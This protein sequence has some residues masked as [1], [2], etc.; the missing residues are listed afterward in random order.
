MINKIIDFCVKHRLFVF[1]ATVV[2]IAVAIVIIANTPVDALPDLSDTQVIVYAKWDRPPQI[3]EDQVTYPIVTALLGAPGVKDI[4]AFS[5]YGYS[6]V[7]AI[8]DDGTDVYWARSRVLEYLSKVNSQL[9]EGVKVELGP[10]ASGVGWIYEYA[11]EDKSGKNSL[12][13]L[14][15]FQDW[16]LKYALQSVK[17]VS[18]VASIGGFVKQY[19]IVVNPDLL[20]YYNVTLSEVIAKVK[21]A[22]QE[23]GARLLDLAGKEYMVTVRGYFKTKEDIEAIVI[24]QE[25]GA[26]LLLRSLARVEIGPEIR[27]GIAEKDGRGGMVGGIVIMRYKENAL[28]VIERVKAKLAEIQMPEGVSVVP[29]YDRSELILRSIETLRKSLI[30]EMIVVA[31]IIIIFLLHLSSSAVPIIT[32]P[33]ATALAFIPMYFL[34]LSSNIMSLGGIAIA[35]GAMVDA[36]IVSVENTHTKLSGWIKAGRVGDYRVTVVDSLKEVGRSAFYSL[37][38]IAVSFIPI[39]T[40]EGI[41]GRLFRPLALTKNLAMFFGALLAITL[42]PALIMTLIRAKRIPI[43]N[44]VL[45][46][47][48]NKVLVGEIHEEEKHPVSRFLFKI[49]NPVI[50]AVLKKPL[51]VIGIAGALFLASMPVF[52]SLG[53]E[54]MPPLNEGSILYMPSTLP[55]ISVTEAQSLLQLQDKILKSFPEVQT[56]F[57]KAGRAETATD[58]APF[59]MMETTIVLKPQS[60]WRKKPQWYSNIL[61]EF[62]KGPLRVFWPDTISYEELIAEMDARLKL[63]GQTNS[64]TLP[65]KGRIDMLTTGVRTPVGIKIYGDDLAQI[66]NLGKEMEKTLMGVKGTRSVFAERTQGGF[67]VD[68][69]LRREALARYGL[70]IAEVQEVLSY[71]V[72]GENITQTFE[73][74]ERFPVNIRYP[75]EFRDDVEKLR[76]LPVP[77]SMS[78]AAGGASTAGGG[79]SMGGTMPAPA[80]G[81]GCW[82]DPGRKRPPVRLCVHRCGGPRY[83]QLCGRSQTRHQG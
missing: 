73:G 60:E 53:R 15:T 9:P 30:E 70:S 3:I 51:L 35:V 26:P 65:V 36:S 13:D 67:F 1:S 74:R 28:A 79:S 10:D 33:I 2:L 49:Y 81:S 75:R 12:A 14:R 47:V 56:V 7:Y 31:V 29:V 43:K 8:F 52:L 76:H 45:D 68:I 58:P 55:G 62:L 57:G 27:R 24:R 40:L 82:H 72:G 59:S 4:R 42:V 48:V 32:L 77:A 11:L 5:D 37:L 16:H 44:K 69:N 41:E 83:R 25:G 71:A 6:Y 22:N 18:E 61:P 23:M 50:D 38:V 17:G 21:T 64:W 63:P 19:Q 20:K 78:A 39:F 46:V 80:A 66:E 34:G 54:F